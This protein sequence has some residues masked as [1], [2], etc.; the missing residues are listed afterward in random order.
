MRVIDPSVIRSPSG[1]ASRSVTK[2]NFRFSN[3]PELRDSITALVVVIET[4][5]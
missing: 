4:S 5:S 3:N 2:N 1:T